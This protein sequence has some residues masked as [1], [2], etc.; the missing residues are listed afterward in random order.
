MRKLSL[1]LLI[2]QSE[3]ESW[4][5]TMQDNS[6]FPRKCFFFLPLMLQ[7]LKQSFK[8][9]LKSCFYDLDFSSNQVYTTLHFS[10]FLFIFTHCFRLIPVDM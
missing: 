1:C 9:N 6:S 2:G 7:A 5:I 10:P 8:S 3:A 4:E